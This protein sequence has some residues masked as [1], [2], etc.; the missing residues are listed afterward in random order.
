MKL[1]QHLFTVYMK[2]MFL[3]VL[4][5]LSIW[6]QLLTFAKKSIYLMELHQLDKSKM[7]K[8][9]KKKSSYA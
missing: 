3:R 2:F 1:T 7:R 8:L 4:L 6:F 9:T 5:S